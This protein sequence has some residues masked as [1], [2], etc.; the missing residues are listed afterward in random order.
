ML[1]TVKK[2]RA[3]GR[4]PSE[5]DILDFVKTRSGHVGK[6]EIARAF[7]IR[8]SKRI[9]LKRLLKSM[10][11]RGLLARRHRKPR[12]AS[13]LPPVAV[14]DLT[15]IDDHGEVFAVPSHWDSEKQ[16]KPPPIVLEATMGRGK[17][18][19]SRVPGVGERI[20]ARL[21]PVEGN[22]D[23]DPYAY[24]ARLIRIL[25]SAPSRIL[26]QLRRA[27][28]YGMRLI[29]VEDKRG[30]DFSLL[31]GGENGAAP[32]ELV[33][34]EPV[35][36]RGGGL[37][38]LRIRERLGRIDDPRNISLIAIHQYAIPD[39][40]PEEVEH[41]ARRLEPWSDMARRIDRCDVPFITI[42]PPDARDHD[43]AVWAEADDA[44]DNEGGFRIIVAIADVAAYVRPGSLLDRQARRRGNSVYFPDRVVPMLP[45]RLSAD[46]CS[47]KA[48]RDRPA[49]ACVM[50][51]DR[52]G[53]KRGHHFERVM[54]RP[55][56]NLTYEQAQSAIDGHGD[57]AT[58]ALLQSVLDPLWAAWHGLSRARKRRA[59]LELDIPERK[60]VLNANGLIER[61]V[62]PARLDAHR[63]IEDMM[64]AANV[65][66]AQ[67]LKRAGIPLIS[68]VH[69]APC[70]KKLAA[71]ASFM[72]SLGVP[73]AKS[74]S[75]RPKHFN[76]ILRKTRSGEY[77]HLVNQLVLRSQAQAMYSLENRGHFGL[78]LKHYTH[79]TSPIRR[80][81]DLIVHRALIA[82]HKF[83][84]DGLSEDDIA[85][86]EET[87]ESIS[88]T[89]RRAMAA[90]R[91]TV[92]RLIAGHLS[93]KVGAVFSGH[94]AGV[95]RAGVFVT[96]DDT[97]A[98]GFV[99]MGSLHHDYFIFD[100]ASHSLIGHHGGGVYRLG[101]R[102]EV[103]LKEV[104]PVAGGLR[105]EMVSPGRRA[106]KTRRQKPPSQTRRGFGR[107]MTKRGLK[108][109]LSRHR[110]S[111]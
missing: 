75:V 79:F 64:I 44:P 58:A 45:E 12:D 67:T 85:R 101:D 96:L 6:G 19:T 50:H 84:D 83:G 48:G 74:E 100:D 25:P 66:A 51:F 36:G 31:P 94:I 4:F 99:P 38:G 40:F 23:A 92:D 71:M 33:Y 13:A 88:D 43:D 59:P 72:R 81:A 89:E 28:R 34:A 3:A 55:A 37:S 62:T 26:G 39:R 63:L 68:R 8:G 1:K 111:E 90:E 29:S 87:A 77:E 21:S 22:Q 54:M 60:L 32:G 109:E 27:G 16:G 11:E 93:E 70:E 69:D 47:L 7:H 56:A 52:A 61:I 9:T 18:G 14:L 97:G 91:A 49:L 30:R 86:M 106:G 78:N 73:F 82:A 108:A 102:V 57:D 107:K 35:R 103:R 80:Y 17:N 98:D 2:T 104:T 42:D 95:T 15:G 53:V 20:L 10:S 41:M 65:S 5:S 46:L 24:R 105:L 76:A 110:P